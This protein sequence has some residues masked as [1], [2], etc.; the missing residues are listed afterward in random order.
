MRDI[1]VPGGLLRL[2]LREE[3]AN[4][5]AVKPAAQQLGIVRVD[6]RKSR[7][8]QLVGALDNV[9]R[10]VQQAELRLARTGER[11]ELLHDQALH[12]QAPF[13]SVGLPSR[14]QH[15][16]RGSRPVQRFA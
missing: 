3:D 16:L 1:E 11:G 9:E 4:A 7:T 2:R 10:L 8:S 12:R 6:C 14:A 15:R 5:G 13:G